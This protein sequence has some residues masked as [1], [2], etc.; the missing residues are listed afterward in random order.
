MILSLSFQSNLFITTVVWGFGLG[1]LYDLIRVLRIA[2][3]HK[4]L[5][6]AVEDILYWVCVSFIIFFVMLSESFGEVRVFCI[7]GVFLG[8]I[9]YSL[10]LSKIFLSF[11]AVVIKTIKKIIMLFVEIIMTP[12]I[13]LMKV[14]G[15]PVKKVYNFTGKKLKK[16]LHLSKIYVRIKLHK[17]T[18]NRK[19]LRKKKTK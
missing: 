7:L 16:L 1:F 10:A 5:F 9:F 11:S 13:L 6:V 12:F 8:M 18:G 3:K 17:F 2:F 15:K 19:V 14:L 4:R